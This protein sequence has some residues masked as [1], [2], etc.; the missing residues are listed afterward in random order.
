[1]K[2]ALGVAAVAGATALVALGLAPADLVVM[3]GNS[4]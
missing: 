2:K 1:M 3:A 4:L